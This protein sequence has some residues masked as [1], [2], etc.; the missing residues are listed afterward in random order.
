MH[1]RTEG[2]CALPPTIEN[3]Y[4]SVK[5]FSC[6]VKVPLLLNGIV[7]ENVREIYGILVKDSGPKKVK[8]FFGRLRV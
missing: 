4:K 5:N 7:M 1:W 3:F 2:H 8:M 6:E